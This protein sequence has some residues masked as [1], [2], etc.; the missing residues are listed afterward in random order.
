MGHFRA[1]IVCGNSSTMAERPSAPYNGGRMAA[2]MRR[3]SQA[4][5]AEIPPQERKK[6]REMTAAT[7]RNGYR[8]QWRRRKMGFDSIKARSFFR[9]VSGPLFREFGEG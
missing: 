7:A 4:K 8:S 3:E 2:P 6:H 9:S 1:G 5:V